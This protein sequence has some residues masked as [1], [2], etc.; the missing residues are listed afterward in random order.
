M[1][2]IGNYALIRSTKIRYFY[3]KLHLFYQK[4]IGFYFT[5][6]S[7]RNVLFY[8]KTKTSR[9]TLVQKGLSGRFNSNIVAALYFFSEFGNI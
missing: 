4:A 5:V 3:I 8:N 6:F 2:N 9:Q 7:G 1:V